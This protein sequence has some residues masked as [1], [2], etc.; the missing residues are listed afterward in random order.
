[1]KIVITGLTGSGKSTL[2]KKLAKELGLKYVS[3]GDLL[4]QIIAG[5]KAGYAGWWETEE[6]EKAMN[7]RKER[8]E[9]DREVDRRLLEI[10]EKE[11]NVL[12]DSW[13][14]SYLYKK[15]DA[16]KIYLKADIEERAKRV[17]RRDGISV[18]EAKEAIEKKDRSSIELYDRLYGFRLDE[19][20]TPFNLVLD[21]TKLDED[22]AFKLVLMYVKRWFCEERG[23]CENDR[24]YSI[25]T[26]SH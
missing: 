14:A 20:L 4:K 19:D 16:V 1:M 23:T 12:V 26:P 15:R 10:M 11:E 9:Y 8:E 5:E 18:E 21:T 13:T 7:K 6:G 17:S 24:S 22:D 25:K 2:G 3:G